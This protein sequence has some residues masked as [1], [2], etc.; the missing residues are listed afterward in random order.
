MSA[1]RLH[2]LLAIAALVIIGAGINA[3]ATIIVQ[4]LLAG[5]LAVITAPLIDALRRRGWS[6]GLILAVM[7]LA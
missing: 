3:A 7:G 4:L 1:R 5:F 2:P 6:M